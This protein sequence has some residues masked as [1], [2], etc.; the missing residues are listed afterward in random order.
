[1]HS[2]FPSRKQSSAAC[3]QSVLN[4][5]VSQKLREIRQMDEKLPFSQLQDQLNQKLVLLPTQ[6]FLSAL[7]Q[8][9]AQPSIIAEVKKA[10]PS[11]GVLRAEFDPIAIAQAYERGGATCLSV[12]TDRQFFQGSFENLRSIRHVVN[13]PLLCKEFIIDPYQIYFARLQGADA[14]LLITAI[15]TDS[16]LQEF[17][18]LTHQLGMD[19]LVEVHTLAEL[20]R[21]LTLSNVKLIG[22]NNRNLA[23]FTINLE[24]TPEIIAARR[25]QVIN[26]TVVSE[27]GLYTRSDLTRMSAAGVQ[28]VL[29]G[30]SLVKQ[31]DIEQALSELLLQPGKS[32]P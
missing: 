5:I 10:S 13:L 11:R 24:T 6:K 22:I 12:L 28:A 15:L 31:P 30:E 19:A 17:L 3:T 23:D 1:M 16:K 9:T 14:I 8:S 21:V 27:S 7:Q 25:S 20:D 26:F 29:I 32:F 4:E 2:T 18:N